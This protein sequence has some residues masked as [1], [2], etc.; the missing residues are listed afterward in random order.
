MNIRQMIISDLDFVLNQTTLEG[1]SSIRLDFEEL[2]HF[3]PK[4]SFIGE[5]DGEPVGMVCTVNYG[6]FGFIGTLI[7]RN[8]YRGQNYGRTLMKIAM[9]HLLD[10]GTKSLLLDGVPKA[11]SLYEQ[12][13]FRKIA[14]SLRLASVLTGQRSE[15]VRQ[16]IPDDIDRI[17]VSD[18][19]HFGGDRKK[20]LQMRFSS[21]PEYCKIL[22]IDEEIQGFIMGRS[23]STSI[24]V[25][26]WV[27]N[28]HSPKSEDL[29]LALAESA[30]GN[31]LK[32]GMLESNNEALKIL[33]KYGFRETSYSWRMLYGENTEATQSDHLYAICC[34]ARG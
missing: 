15:Y 25:G 6:E 5:V 7:V 24:R 21:F 3:N 1:W 13:G 26:P 31:T 22:E 20:F 18:T 19:S 14:K 30:S 8:I 10:S 12:L 29:L 34:P 11:V 16:M 4:G 17:S 2:L 9:K 32:I 23:G 27:M 28:N 33:K